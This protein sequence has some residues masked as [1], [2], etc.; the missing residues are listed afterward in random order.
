MQKALSWVLVSLFKGSICLQTE[1]FLAWFRPARHLKILQEIKTK[2][3]NKKTEVTRVQQTTW[4][5]CKDEGK[6]KDSPVL[7]SGMEQA[8][9]E[10]S[11][12]TTSF[13]NISHS[14]HLPLPSILYAPK[15][16]PRHQQGVG[17]EAKKEKKTR[18]EVMYNLPLIIMVSTH[19]LFTYLL[20]QVLFGYIY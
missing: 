11:V 12:T 20:C 9:A 10:T 15:S 3:N 14:N 16:F 18:T 19:M 5:E 1:Y 7:V 8:G 17:S 4:T 13:R 6:A 2:Q